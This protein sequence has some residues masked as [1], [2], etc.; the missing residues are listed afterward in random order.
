M[1]K[2]THIAAAI[3]AALMFSAGA[4]AADPIMAPAGVADAYLAISNFAIRTAD[5][6]ATISGI[7]VPVSPIVSPSPITL[8]N[9][10][11]TGGTSSSLNGSPG[12][13]T[14]NGGFDADGDVIVALNPAAPLDP[15]SFELQTLAGSGYTPLAT[16][17]SGTYNAGSSYAAGYANHDG[18]ALWFPGAPVGTGNTLAQLHSQVNLDGIHDGSADAN[19]TLGFNAILSIAGGPLGFEISF[20]AEGFL[21]SQLAQD[22]LKADASHTF[23]I[24]ITELNP[25]TGA[26]IDTVLDWTPNGRNRG[27]IGGISNNGLLEDEGSCVAAGTCVEYYDGASSLTG[28]PNGTGVG[29]LDASTAV[30]STAEDI[31]AAFSESYQLEIFLNPGRYEF[32]LVQ[33][34]TANAT[35]VPEPGMLALLGLGMVGFGAAARRSRKA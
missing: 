10:S 35:T 3:G 19:Q 1:T 5:G 8:S 26:V 4:Q 2:R 28:A 7:P 21:R 27:S 9:L 18:N 6:A 14:L 13:S 23:S 25:T 11:V 12:A 17:P 29:D 20:D 22:G 15:V 24:K 30:S 34:T 32:S 16:L 31:I 33:T